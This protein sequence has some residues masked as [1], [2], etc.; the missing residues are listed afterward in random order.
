LYV[1]GHKI[2]ETLT[3]DLN[4]NS[5][6]KTK[7]Q[8]TVV[9]GHQVAVVSDSTI[10]VIGGIM[11][12]AQNTDQFLDVV[13]LFTPAKN[14]WKRGAP[15]P[16]GPVGSMAA[17]TIDGW[18]Y[19]CGGLMRSHV[20]RDCA[21][22]S[23]AHNKW[24]KVKNMRFPVHHAAAG[25][26]GEKMYV[27]GGR[28]ST[29]NKVVDG[30]K[31]IQIYNPGN[32]KWSLSAAV[33]PYKNAGMGAAPFLN[34]RFY[35]TGGET[36]SQTALATAAKVFEQTNSFDVATQKWRE[37][38]SIPVGLHGIFPVADSERNRI[39]VAG[40]A[41]NAGRSPSSKDFYV[42]VPPQTESADAI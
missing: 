33:L 40:G 38:A 15:Y 21:K 17:V 39:Y 7:A 34:G 29:E 31:F 26:D 4:R 27:F 8:R 1:F 18:V 5:W 16:H 42:F 13:Q 19:G 28:S 12:V 35:L 32:N 2:P 37:E 41:I 22:Y 10:V 9:S 6:S 36:K 24:Q 30:S 23:V 20:S 11:G 14:R 3:F 25:T